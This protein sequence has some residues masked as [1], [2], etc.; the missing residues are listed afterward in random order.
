MRSRGKSR[1]IADCSATHP[2]RF[3]ILRAAIW[4]G[5]R[6]PSGAHEHRSQQ[7]NESA[8]SVTSVSSVMN[9]RLKQTD[10]DAELHRINVT[11]I[12]GDAVFNVISETRSELQRWL[13]SGAVVL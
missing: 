13:L 1:P 6:H 3:S 12:A 4:I 5:S 8:S 10:D 9:M 2:P 7:R 11:T